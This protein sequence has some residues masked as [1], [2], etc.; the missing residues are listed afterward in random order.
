MSWTK[1][2]GTWRCFISKCNR[3]RKKWL[4]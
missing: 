3:R 2:S 4:G 1:R